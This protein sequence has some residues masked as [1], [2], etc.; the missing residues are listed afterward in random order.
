MIQ[1]CL[2][3]HHGSS[4]LHYFDLSKCTLPI[5]NLKESVRPCIHTCI[6]NTQPQSNEHDK[7]EQ[8]IGCSGRQVLIHMLTRMLL[9]TQYLIFLKFK[10]DKEELVYNI[11]GP[12]DLANRSSLLE[13]QLSRVYF[14]LHKCCWWLKQVIAKEVRTSQQV[15]DVSFSGILEQL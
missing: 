6:Q 5:A 15:I 8:K 11:A 10:P 13:T 1:Y 2:C 12:T 4:P 7:T 3:R 14:I 9:S